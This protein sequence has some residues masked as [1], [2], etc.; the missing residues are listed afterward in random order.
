MRQ[1]LVVMCD[2]RVIDRNAERA[3]ELQ[4]RQLPEP[5]EQS[6]G[7]TPRE[8]DLVALA[9]P[10]ERARED[11]QLALLL[12]RGHD[13]ELRLPALERRD[14]RAR[15]RTH[16]AA[17]IARRT[18]RRAELHQP[19]VEIAGCE[20]V[21]QRCH[22]LAGARPQHL[23]PR[24]GLDVVGDAEH[25]RQHARDVAV[26]ER[27]ALAE[28]DARDRTRGVRTDARHLAE[29]RRASR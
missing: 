13:R 28:R 17:W 5:T 25:A 18:Q 26:D 3:R 23:R 1:R 7:S 27:S 9:D 29:L 6:V 21:G 2:R 4:W 12:A 24:S 20:C 16:E 22:Q 8:E 19:L 15:E 11:R 10:H 14:T